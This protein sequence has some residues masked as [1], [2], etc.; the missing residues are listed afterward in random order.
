MKYKEIE[1]F[2]I[3]NNPDKV[4]A[5][6]EDNAHHFMNSIYILLE[7]NRSRFTLSEDAKK[8]L[9]SLALD[10]EYRLNKIKL[11]EKEKENG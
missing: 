9:Q 1:M 4:N 6:V 2:D 7:G 3:I 8:A 11:K 5:I 10:I